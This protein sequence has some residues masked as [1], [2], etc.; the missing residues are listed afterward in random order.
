MIV[1]NVVERCDPHTRWSCPPFNDVLTR[2][3]VTLKALSLTSKVF[4]EPCSNAIWHTQI[5]LIP[6]LRSIDILEESTTLEEWGLETKYV[7]PTEI[8]T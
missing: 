8:S 3:W 4:Q 7:R 2:S 5:S 6:L 1:G